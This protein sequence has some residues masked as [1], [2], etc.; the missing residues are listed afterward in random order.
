MC[1]NV[2]CTP[3]WALGKDNKEGDEEMLENAM[4]VLSQ[5]KEIAEDSFH[6][7]GTGQGLLQYGINLAT[8]A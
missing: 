7:T 4:G 3:L 8:L 1:S 5:M 2:W 6:E